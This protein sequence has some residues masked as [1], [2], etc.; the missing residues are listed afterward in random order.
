MDKTRS[1]GSRQ[2][3]R[4]ASFLLILGLFG[5]TIAAQCKA[6]GCTPQISATPVVIAPGQGDVGVAA[7]CPQGQFVTGG[8]CRYKQ[9]DNTHD[10]TP[11]FRISTSVPA[12]ISTQQIPGTTAWL[13]K[14]QNV[15]SP[16]ELQRCLSCCPNC[17]PPCCNGN[18]PSYPCPD[19]SVCQ[20]GGGDPCG[21]CGA[22][23]TFTAVAMCC[24]CPTAAQASAAGS[25]TP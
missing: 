20:C 5:V 6:Q 10:A 19:P 18:D 21:V 1:S 14:F 8:G 24:G 9:D 17:C 22:T 13:C 25:H 3:E 7:E 11:L 16:Q 23:V 15:N 12:D 4:L 2:G